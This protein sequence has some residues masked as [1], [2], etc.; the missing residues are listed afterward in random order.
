[1]EVQ[2]LRTKSTFEDDQNLIYMH[3][4]I[5]SRQNPLCQLARS[6]RQAKYRRKYQQFLIEGEN[7]VTNALTARW[8]LVAVIS[9]LEAAPKIQ[10][11]LTLHQQ[12]P[13]ILHQ[14]QEDVLQSVCETQ[15]SPKVAAIA[16]LKS[17][18]DEGLWRSAKVLLVLDGVSDP[19][20]LGTLLR[21]ADASGVDGVLLT[22]HCV[23]PFSPKVVRS[24]AGSIFHC[25]VEIL[26]TQTFLFKSQQYQFEL[27]AASAHNGTNC[28]V[29]LWPQKVCLIL[30]NEKQGIS[31]ELLQASKHQITI[32][33]R[34]RAESLNVAM[35]GTVLM[36]KAVDTNAKI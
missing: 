1:M 13:T 23:D 16:T 4:T 30:G 26:D 18:F 19:G 14:I 15:T 11:L 6:L 10:D 12:D 34:G 9:T 32:P 3:D 25:P 22:G 29:F 5:S 28:D 36:F 35:A 27:V 33:I 2:F 20:N 31:E 21:A 7:A 17:T 24:S 8:E